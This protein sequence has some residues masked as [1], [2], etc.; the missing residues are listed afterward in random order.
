MAH[1][2]QVQVL[3]EEK[4]G[5]EKKFNI[6]KQITNRRGKGKESETGLPGMR[7]EG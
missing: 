1:C 5:D 7:T 6:K 2:L 3:L 4:G